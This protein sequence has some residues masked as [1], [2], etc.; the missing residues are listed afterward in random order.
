MGTM[1]SV[2]NQIKSYPLGI[3][4]YPKEGLFTPTSDQK[5]PLGTRYQDIEGNVYYYAKAGGTALVAG[6]ILTQAALGGAATTA[7]T[8]LAVATSSAIG[9][10]FGYATIVT[11]AQ[12]GGLFDDGYY[13]IEAGTAAQGRGGI[14]KIKNDDVV[15]DL[16]GALTAASHKFT[17]YEPCRTAITAGSAT[18]RLMTNPY[19]ALVQA[20]ATT[21]VGGIVGG[22][23][24]AVTA[25]YYFWCQTWGVFNAL[26]AGAMTP[27][28][29]CL[30]AV[31]IAGA[32]T[33]DTAALD[34]QVV[35]YSLAS[36]ADTENGP[37]ML[38]LR[39]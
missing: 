35:G 9:D 29:S 7:Q 34:D 1:L 10:K 28:R 37:I 5:Y 2:E 13:C 20:A 26:A 39:P 32:V 8:N 11:T 38:T 36:I 14:Y 3:T 27:G 19:K 31:A 22:A 18:V 23:P 12:V 25:N 15:K 6:N 30:N 21:A 24:V 33:L 4:G 16:A 17:F